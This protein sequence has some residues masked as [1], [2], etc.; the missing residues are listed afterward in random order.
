MILSYDVVNVSIFLSQGDE[1]KGNWPKQ[2]KSV[3]RRWSHHQLLKDQ[4]G[5]DEEKK[6]RADERQKKKEAKEA[7]AEADQAA[8]DAKA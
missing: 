4:E 3:L 5:E 1:S 2:I 6:K 8:K 7:K